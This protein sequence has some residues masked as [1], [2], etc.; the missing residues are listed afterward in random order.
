MADEEPVFV[1]SFWPLCVKIMKELG[2]KAYRFSV[3]WPRIFP[4]GH[5]KINEKGLKF[6]RELI[7]ELIDN[8]IVEFYSDE[9]KKKYIFA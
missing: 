1:F 5:G 8:G 7:E 2:L 4:E 6:Y 3:S 9:D